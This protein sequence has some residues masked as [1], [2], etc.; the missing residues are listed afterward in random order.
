MEGSTGTLMRTKYTGLSEFYRKASLHLSHANP[1]RAIHFLVSVSVPISQPE[2]DKDM[3][4]PCI[5]VLGFPSTC[6]RNMRQLVEALKAFVFSQHGGRRPG[7]Q[8]WLV[9]QC[10]HQSQL[11][12]ISHSASTSRHH[13]QYSQEKKEMVS[14]WVTFLKSHL[15]ICLYLC[16]CQASVACSLSLVAETR[17]YSVAVCGSLLRWVLL[18]PGT[19]PRVLLAMRLGFSSFNTQ[20]SKCCSWAQSL[21]HTGLVVPWHVESAW[22]RIE[23]GVPLHWQVDPYL[24][25]HQEV[26]WVPFLKIKETSNLWCHWPDWF[27]MFLPEQNH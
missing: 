3:V 2:Q 19:G 10:N 4:P 13:I 26:P 27:Q 20:L 12:S 6:G 8:S 16:L 14:F 23:P 9:Q 15:F 24:L 21:W 22:T 17:R 11:P 25:H 1:V 7:L 18:L 5:P